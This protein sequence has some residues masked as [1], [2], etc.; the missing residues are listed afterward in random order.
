MTGKWKKDMDTAY[1]EYKATS[2]DMKAFI[3]NMK[4]YV[5]TLNETIETL[6]IEIKK[7]RKLTKEVA[8]SHQEAITQN[9]GK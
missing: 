4:Q 9:Y 8:E 6:K 3:D 5:V 1:L 2:A 7:Q